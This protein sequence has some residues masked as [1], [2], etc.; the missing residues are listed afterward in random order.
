MF[1][2]WWLKAP[3]FHEMVQHI[4][5]KEARSTNKARVLHIKLARL[6][7]AL[8]RWNKERLQLL[9]RESKEAEELVL[10]LNQEQDTQPLTTAEIQDRRDAKT[11][12]WE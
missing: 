11:E 3:G 1:E 8:K 12:F 6:T 4:W 9:K 5:N 7:K 2:S 10:K